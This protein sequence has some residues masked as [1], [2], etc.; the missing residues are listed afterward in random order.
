MHRVYE[1][2]EV[3]PNGAPRR[4]N[5]VSGLEFA[6]VAL[7]GLARRTNNECFIA[8][9]NTRHVVMQMNVPRAK[10]RATKRVFQIAYDEGTGL[11]RAELLRS[12]G[13][14][15]ISVTGNE[16]AKL[17][18]SS[19]QHYDFFIVGHAAPE[20]TRR[21]IVAWLRAT[22]PSVKILAMNPP[23]QQILGADYNVQQNGPEAWLPIVSQQLSNSASNGV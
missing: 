9:A 18:L 16:P 20:K 14:A 13:Y 6:K 3:M 22:Y 5:L 15:V 1:I 23:N 10:L 4:V 2:F 17:L 12:L 21:E 19:I 8:D 11:R 7:Q